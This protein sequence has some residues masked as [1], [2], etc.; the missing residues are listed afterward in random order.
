MGCSGLTIPEEASARR[1]D[2][3]LQKTSKAWAPNLALPLTHSMTLGASWP[4]WALR[5]PH[6]TGTWA[7]LRCGARQVSGQW[8]T[9]GLFP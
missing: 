8:V 7:R 9:G 3:I 4:L 2:R 1:E 5:C 6:Q